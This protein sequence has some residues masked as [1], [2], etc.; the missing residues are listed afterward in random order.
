VALDLDYYARLR[1][2]GHF[3]WTGKAQERFPN[4]PWLCSTGTDRFAAFPGGLPLRTASVDAVECAETLELTRDEVGAFRE[5]ARVLRPGGRLRLQVPATGPLA[6]LDAINLYKYVGEV[7]GRTEL[8]EEAL[9]TGWR[10]HY[11]QADIEQLA[12]DR[13]R[14]ERVERRGLGLGEAVHF[15]AMLSGKWRTP[16]PDLYERLRGM[17]NRLSECE[18]RTATPWGWCATYHLVRV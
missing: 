4:R 13:F 17:A 3:R 10:R 8:V 9:E 11:S 12:G 2:Q 18:L 6:A 16:R 14:I 5:I 1:R 15:A 7:A